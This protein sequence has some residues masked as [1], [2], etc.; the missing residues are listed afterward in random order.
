[1]K[2]DHITIKKIEKF[3]NIA[4]LDKVFNPVTVNGHKDEETVEIKNKNT[5]KNLET[6][7]FEEKRII[8]NEYSITFNKKTHRQR[9]ISFRGEKTHD[10]F[11]VYNYKGF[12]IGSDL[13][14][15][16]YDFSKNINKMA[17]E[18]VTNRSKKIKLNNYSIN[19]FELVEKIVDSGFDIEIIS[20]WFTN[21]NLP[22]LNAVKLE[23]NEVND[24][25]E[26]TKYKANNN[27]RITS[28]GLYINVHPFNRLKLTIS[29]TADIYIPSGGIT[30]DD[31][32]VLT[33][34]IIEILTKQ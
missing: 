20:T 22:N 11:D 31:A 27:S 1:M 30:E 14:I 6:N 19:L 16:L 3:D 26:W 17:M 33:N 21:L 25:N 13:F 10:F 5:P 4:T 9:P 23:G 29:N 24:G 8:L 7:F 32:L 15:N 34:L 28:L 2:I 12:K 18:K